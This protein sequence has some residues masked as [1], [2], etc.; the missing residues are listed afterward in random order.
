MF[1][2]A[3]LVEVAGVEPASKKRDVKVHPQAWSI[4]RDLCRGNGQP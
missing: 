3:V 2:E 4:F 1:S